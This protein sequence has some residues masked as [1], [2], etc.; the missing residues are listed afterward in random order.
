VP[1]L[2]TRRRVCLF[3]D[4]VVTFTASSAR[5][6]LSIPAG[7]EKAFTVTLGEQPGEK[8]A[9]ATPSRGSGKADDAGTLRCC[10][11]G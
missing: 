9:K 4:F 8:T 3:A 7:A 10:R 5:Q 6:E 1:L 2:Q 11:R